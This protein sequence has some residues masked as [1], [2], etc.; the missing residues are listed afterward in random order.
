MHNFTFSLPMYNNNVQQTSNQMNF[1]NSMYGPPPP[2]PPPQSFSAQNY[3][4]QQQQQQQWNYNGYQQPYM[5][6]N[7]MYGGQVNPMFSGMMPTMTP[8]PQQI[9][10]YS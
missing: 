4:M 2:S 3:Y 1:V 5:Q 7:Q 10:V 9:P 6:T 8:P